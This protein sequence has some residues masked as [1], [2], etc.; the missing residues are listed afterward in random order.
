MSE[1]TW[2]DGIKSGAFHNSG[3]NKKKK[4]GKSSSKHGRS[5]REGIRKARMEKRK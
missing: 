2:D 1:K 4:N 3:T 5:P